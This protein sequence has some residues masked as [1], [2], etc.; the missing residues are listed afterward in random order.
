MI[1][2]SYSKQQELKANQRSFTAEGFDPAL[3]SAST[4]Y[5]GSWPGT[6]IDANG[7]YWQSGY[8]ACAGNPVPDHVF[9]RLLIPV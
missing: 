8:P 6:I 4:N 7:N 3:G 9:R 2:A 5:P 1:T